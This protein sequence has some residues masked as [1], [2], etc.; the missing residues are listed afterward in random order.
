[1]SVR[2]F[3]CIKSTKGFDDFGASGLVFE[4][5]QTTKGKI[6]KEYQRWDGKKEVPSGYVIDDNACWNEIG[7]TAFKKLF[8]EIKDQE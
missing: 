5:N 7:T 1:M 3:I 6:Y 2:K 8:E 4:V